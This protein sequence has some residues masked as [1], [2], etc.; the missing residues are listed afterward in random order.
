MSPKLFAPPLEIVACL[1]ASDSCFCWVFGVGAWINIAEEIDMAAWRPIAGSG[2]LFDVDVAAAG[3]GVRPMFN[4]VD[5]T[6]E[7]VPR[8]LL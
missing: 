6:T 2:D 8:R 5:K 7:S 4:E 1:F 3:C